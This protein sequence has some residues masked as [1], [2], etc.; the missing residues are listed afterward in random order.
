[1]LTTWGVVLELPGIDDEWPALAARW[2]AQGRGAYFERCPQLAAFL[3]AE[4]ADLRVTA[5]RVG[6]L[7][8]ASC[9]GGMRAGVSVVEVRRSSFDM[10]VR[11]RATGD[12]AGRPVNGRCTIVVERCATGERIPVPRE[13]RDE[14]IAI[15]LA[16][17]ELC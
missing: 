5:E 1:M 12:G 7:A 13:V 8:D 4:E 2:F 10:A 3:R 17:R 14:F 16:A 9:P 15:Q 11:F 6:P